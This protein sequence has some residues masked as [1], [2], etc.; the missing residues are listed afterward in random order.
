MRF[1]TKINLPDFFLVIFLVAFVGYMFYW[2]HWGFDTK[3]I[4]IVTKVEEYT[5]ERNWL[6]TGKEIR[7]GIQLTSEDGVII[8]QTTYNYDTEL[9]N[10]IG[11]TVL[12]NIEQCD[13]KFGFTF[14]QK[15]KYI[16]TG[17][18]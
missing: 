17:G 2:Y 13:T 3:T 16:K 12:V 1:R 7:T 11:E 15:P 10:H 18:T 5:E 6:Y 4:K 14:Y 8:Y 9:D